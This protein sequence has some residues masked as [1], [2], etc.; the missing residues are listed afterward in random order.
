MSFDESTG[1]YQKD[2]INQATGNLSASATGMAFGADGSLW[3]ADWTGNQ[4]VQCDPVSG[5][6]L[7]NITV[8]NPALIAVSSDAKLYVT[9][10][11]SPSRIVVLDS[12]TGALEKQFGEQQLQAAR[13][14]KFGPQGVLYVA[15]LLVG[16]LRFTAGGEFMDIIT[17]AAAFHSQS[18]DSYPWGLLFSADGNLLVS[19]GATRVYKIDP[20]TGVI[21]STFVS[22]EPYGL[23]GVSG[24][25][26][27][28]D[29]YLYLVSNNYVGGGVQGVL[30]FD[31]TTGAFKDVFAQASPGGFTWGAQE[32]LFTRRTPPV[33]DVPVLPPVTGQCSASLVP[34][35]ATDFY[36]HQV[37]GVT[38]DPLVYSAQGTH[39]VRWT[40]FDG[41]GNTTTQTQSVTVRDTEAPEPEVPALPKVTGQ[42]SAEVIAV[43][44]AMDNCA[45]RVIGSTADPLVYHEPGTYIVTWIYDD[46]HG[47][48]TSQEQVVEVKD[49]QPPLPDATE[50]PD[51]IGQ[52]SVSIVIPPT[53]TDNCA[54]KVAGETQDPLTYN[55]QG[56]YT[57]LWS[58]D[59][60]HGNTSS[61]IQK[62]VVKDTVPPV[63]HAATASPGFI[64]PPNNKM[65]PVTITV[66]ATDNGPTAT[67]RIVAVTS[68]ENPDDSVDWEITDD[69]T[70]NL[71][72][73]R[74]GKG[75]GRLYFI[76]VECT[77]AVNN[78]TTTMV[79][80]TV[81]HD[82]GQ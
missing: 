1:T 42:C 65:V 81:P 50:L 61:Q 17:P 63:I 66:E 68:N 3:I 33:P 24:M 32:V 49:T 43:P 62:V 54:G 4:V 82:R 38:T 28:P 57:V 79:T 22:G 7:G 23:R 11:Q 64:W 78:S 25:N 76:T 34:P 48:V 72:A 60:G 41:T 15:D 12:V 45:G 37:V 18:A 75:E 35:T 56:T 21:L 52:L 51:I 39:E 80:V 59:D 30:R 13:G 46:S 73:A 2:L 29:G 8:M 9:S 53:A 77:D 5:T 55:A 19:D 70:L 74:T 58:Y 26:I 71:R 6:V 69:L 31:A 44:T 20:A 14:I 16:V 67:S 47:N 10:G 27:G 40:Y 36:G